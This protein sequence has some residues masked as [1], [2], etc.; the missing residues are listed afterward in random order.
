MKYL[1]IIPILALSAC[2]STDYGQ[3]A[4]AQS[5]IAA[6]RAASDAARYKALAEIASKGDPAS[7]VAAV[8][9]I[10]I[11]GSQQ[12][13]QQQVAAPQRSDALQ[14]AS[15]IIP[16]LTQ[17]YAIGKSAD[18]AINSSNNAMQ[19]SVATTGA[20]VNIA[21]KIQAPV[22]AAPVLPQAN[23]STVTTTTSTDSHDTA[24]SADQTMSG[25]GVLGSGAYSTQ[26]NPITTTTTTPAPVIVPDVIQIV[27][28]A[29]VIVPDVVQIVPVVQ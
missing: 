2:A 15:I 23:V 11:G 6:A 7:S 20:F 17:A 26:A 24:S 18:V 5:D 19:T 29:P 25:V 14:W 4:K 16:G 9:A 3:Y 27:P 21:G 1:A 8:M 28:A 12:Q 22:V 13:G 10:A